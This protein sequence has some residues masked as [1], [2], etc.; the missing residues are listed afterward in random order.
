M[1]WLTNDGT[2]VDIQGGLYEVNHEILV[3]NA[4]LAFWEL[5]VIWT[6]LCTYQDRKN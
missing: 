2:I 6:K 5:I 4:L 3:S 1:L